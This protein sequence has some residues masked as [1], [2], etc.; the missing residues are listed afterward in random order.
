MLLSNLRP[1]LVERG[2]SRRL[3]GS[4]MTFFARRPCMRYQY[5][6]AFSRNTASS[7]LPIPPLF[8]TLEPP[9]LQ[10]MLPSPKLP[11]TTNT[12]DTINHVRPPYFLPSF[13]PSFLP[14]RLP[15]ACAVQVRASSSPCLRRSQTPQPRYHKAVRTH[16]T[17][18]NAVRRR[19]RR[20]R[21]AAAMSASGDTVCLL[22]RRHGNCL[23]AGRGNRVRERE[24]PNERTNERTRMPF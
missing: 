11:R 21:G 6:V 23:D 4:V 22:R 3:S 20:H 12:I 15:A 1:L 7:A 18:E 24:W 17:R 19:R 10:C 9:T 14:A 5:R 16:Q 13:L 2:E 8:G